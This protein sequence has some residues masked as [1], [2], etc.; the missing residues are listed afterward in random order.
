MLQIGLQITTLTLLDLVQSLRHVDIK[1]WQQ[2]RLGLDTKFLHL[3][4]IQ[5]EILTAQRSYPHELHLA[6]QDIEQHGQLVE[7]GLAQ[8]TAPARHTVVVAELA[9]L[10][11]VVVLVH[12]G[13]QVLGI[14]VHGAELVY[15]ENLAVL[16]HPTQLHQGTI[17]VRLAMGL[18]L[19]LPDDTT[20]VVDVLLTHHLKTTIIE[21]TQNLWPR[22]D[23]SLFLVAEIIETPRQS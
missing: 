13:L 16:A 1:R 21:P 22:E 9:A 12:I 6:F 18:T 3:R 2:A 7:P 10:V 23:L 17:G 19:L 5:T 15:V 20:T 4:T 8:E 11:Q 14:G